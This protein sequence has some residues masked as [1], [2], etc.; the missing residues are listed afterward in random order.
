MA[1]ESARRS[2]LA[3][4][5]IFI[6]LSLVFALI[7]RPLCDIEREKTD[8]VRGCKEE[9]KGNFMAVY[10]HYM[11]G[12]KKSSCP[13]CL[14]QLGALFLPQGSDTAK[15]EGVGLLEIECREGSTKCLLV[16]GEHEVTVNA[17]ETPEYVKSQ[18]RL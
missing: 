1:P 10:R 14:A 12:I 18:R 11:Q 9:L 8:Y 5:P 3:T 17:K 13:H 16:L 7:A 2:S 6:C 4:T 15:A